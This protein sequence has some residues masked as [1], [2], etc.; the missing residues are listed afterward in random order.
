MNRI[1]N[2]I[3]ALI[4]SIGSLSAQYD[5]QAREVLD[6]MSEKY[7]LM[8]GFNS[9]FIYTL[10]NPAEG[11]ND[12]Y[13]GEIEIS[14]NKYRLDLGTQIIINDGTTM[15]TY[16]PDVEEVN[17]SDYVPE[18]ESLSL[19]NIFDVYKSGYKYIVNPEYTTASI[20]TV[21]LIPEDIESEFFK[22]RMSIDKSSE[23]KS[24]KIFEKNGNRYIYKIDQFEEKD[25][26]DPKRFIFDEANYPDV[27][28]VDFR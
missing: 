3:L 11:I 5:E 28:V 10:E 20:T 12:S 26:I 22:I 7:R 19:N 21:D 4:V 17:I 8:K 25:A 2:I 18:E 15:W 24:F 27:E 9:V 14:E 6:K 23:L 13:K 1:T 16:M